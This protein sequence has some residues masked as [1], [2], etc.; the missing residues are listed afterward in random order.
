MRPRF[1]LRLLLIAFTLLAILFGAAAHFVYRIKEQARR[2][3]AAEARLEELGCT[4]GRWSSRPYDGKPGTWFHFARKWIDPKAFP[5]RTNFRNTERFSTEQARQAL[6]A[7]REL[8]GLKWLTL[9]VDRLTSEI[10]D[11]LHQLR[12]LTSVTLRVKS[13]DI[14][15]ARCLAN[16]PLKHSIEIE[17]SLENDVAQ[18]LANDKKIQWLSVDPSKLTASS[19]D[20]LRHRPLLR[21][22]ELNVAIESPQVLAALLD[23]PDLNGVYFSH[24]RIDPTAL[25]NLPA[26]QSVQYV[27]FE[28]CAP[29][30]NFASALKSWTALTRIDIKSTQPTLPNSHSDCNHWRL[31]SLPGHNAEFI[32]GEDSFTDHPELSIVN[33]FEF[34]SEMDDRTIFEILSIVPNCEIS[35]FDPAPPT[36]KSNVFRCY[37][38]ENGKVTTLRGG[39]VC[40]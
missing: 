24:C 29:P 22:I 9:N 31:A 36:K 23:H 18:F 40:D 12:E 38:W 4:F 26:N 35:I 32:I 11:D 20:A 6:M 39:I 10:T 3:K 15:G 25:T 28:D 21:A 8:Q 2:H 13:L 19:A 1:S 34:T 14:A 5:A 16:L 30:S 7:A 37:K 33:R 17:L 27:D